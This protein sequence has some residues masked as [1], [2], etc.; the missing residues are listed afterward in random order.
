MLKVPAQPMVL[1]RRACDLTLR[2]LLSGHRSILKIGSGQIIPA[3]LRGTRRA[4]PR[5]HATDPRY[6]F[7]TGKME[8]LGGFARAVV[9]GFRFSAVW[10]RVPRALEVMATTAG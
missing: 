3:A 6:S 2:Q 5:Q 7:G 1:K 8:V 10:K 9:N 4:L